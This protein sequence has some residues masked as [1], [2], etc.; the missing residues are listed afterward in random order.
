METQTAASRY[1]KLASDRTTFLDTARDCAVLSL[2]FLLAPSGLAS[3]QKLA[4]PWQSIG[5]KGANAMASKLM[6]SL[7]PVNTTF[8]KLQINDGQ[9]AKDQALNAKIRSEIDISLSKM[10][11]VVMQ[12]IAESRNETPHCYGECPCLHGF[13][14]C[15]VVSS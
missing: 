12:N 7:F 13:Q 1:A 14:G 6:L 2:P 9:L 15:Q 5:A 8:F 10:E 3:G 11:R 4:T